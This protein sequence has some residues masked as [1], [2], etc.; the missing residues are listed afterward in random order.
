MSTGP[1][2]SPQH[3]GDVSHEKGFVG[4]VVRTDPE[5]GLAGELKSRSASEVLAPLFSVSTVPVAL[6]FDDEPVRGKPNVR[7]PQ[8]DSVRGI[9]VDVHVHMR[10]PR[11]SEDHPN[12]RLR[13]RLG[14]LIEELGGVQE[15]TRS[16]APAAG[17]RGLRQHPDGCA[18]PPPRNEKISCDDEFA[19][20]EGR[21]QV[22]PCPD[23][24]RHGQPLGLPL[25]TGLKPQLVPNDPSDPYRTRWRLNRHMEALVVGHAERQRHTEKLRR[26]LMA[27]HCGRRHPCRKSS[28]ALNQPELPGGRDPHPPERRLQVRCTKSLA[29]DRRGDG[30]GYPERSVVEWRLERTGLHPN[31]C[32]RFERVAPDSFHRLAQLSRLALRHVSEWANRDNWEALGWGGAGAGAGGRGGR[33]RA[34]GRGGGAGGPAGRGRQTT[35]AR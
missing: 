25:F 7:T 9:D 22:T 32:G 35:S 10:K 29:G 18:W 33:G 5:Y 34:G 27:E 20:T 21:G 26:S 13:R 15:Q 24:R 12:D 17:L 8:K 3:P 28:A 11:L 6:V 31:D 16:A 23:V 19:Q 1:T 30:I 2:K 4:K 14:S